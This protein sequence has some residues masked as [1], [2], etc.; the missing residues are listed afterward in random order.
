GPRRL[1]IPQVDL[2][3]NLRLDKVRG[4]PEVLAWRS[5]CLRSPLEHDVQLGPNELRIDDGQGVLDRTRRQYPIEERLRRGR[6]G[7]DDRE[8][9]RALQGV[10]LGQLREEGVVA[11]E[12]A[13]PPELRLGE[14]QAVPAAEVQALLERPEVREIHL[15]V[16]S[17]LPV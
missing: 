1:D 12:E 11:D 5:D 3:Q 15:A 10:R 7:G 16:G 2:G 13:D 8:D 4:F 17:D 6:G 9:V 14:S